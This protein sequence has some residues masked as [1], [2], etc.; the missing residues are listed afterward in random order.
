MVWFDLGFEFLL[1]S[2]SVGEGVRGKGEKKL[3]A[4]CQVEEG[5]TPN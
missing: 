4:A 1:G 3:F 5:L 2:I